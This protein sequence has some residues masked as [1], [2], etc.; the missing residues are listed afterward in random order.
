MQLYAGDAVSEMADVRVASFNVENLFARPA[1]FSV[2]TGAV[3]D[4]V[5]AD[6]REFNTLIDNP[7]YSVPDRQRLRDLLGSL[8]A[9][10]V[11]THGA[12]RRRF[13]QTPAWAWLRKNRGSFDTEPTDSTRDVE[14]IATGRSSWIGWLS[15]A[16][17]F[18]P[19]GP[20]VSC[21]QLP[22]FDVGDRPGTFAPCALDDRLD[23]NPGLQQ[24]G[25]RV[26]QR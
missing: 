20:L 8:D 22:G 3:G 21:Y 4:Q 5:L 25:P 7:V 11:N 14:I 16:T 6:Y 18:D 15:L 9:Y 23:Y 24:P 1:A 10:Y 26:S 2:D 19:K 17:L 12:V 13:T